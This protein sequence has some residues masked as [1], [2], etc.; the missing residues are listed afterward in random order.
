MGSRK[1]LRHE[2][3]RPRPL[4][5]R[6]ARAV[7]G[8]RLGFGRPRSGATTLLPNHVE[9]GRLFRPGPA[10]PPWRFGFTHRGR[11]VHRTGHARSSTT[12]AA[13][14]SWWGPGGTFTADESRAHA[15]GPSVSMLW[16]REARR[17][18][19][20]SA[21]AAAAPPPRAPTSPPPPPTAPPPRHPGLHPHCPRPSGTAQR[22]HRDRDGHQR[23][24]R[25]VPSHRGRGAAVHQLFG[26]AGNVPGSRDLLR[27]G[28][29]PGVPRPER[30]AGTHLLLHGR[31]REHGGHLGALERG[32]CQYRERTQ[33]H[34]RGQHHLHNRDQRHVHDHDG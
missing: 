28:E 13:P 21:A 22:A 1:A 31:G 26:L 29:R 12:P 32:Q 3:R 16:A 20:H 7:D 8:S 33:H 6:E 24:P 30:A 5:R 10:R 25:L 27:R 17:G 4:R 15:R 2:R 11:G 23:D 9:R 34:Q 18:A 14:R 19:S